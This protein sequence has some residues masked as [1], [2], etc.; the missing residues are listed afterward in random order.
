MRIWVGENGI[1]SLE[2]IKM[3]LHIWGLGLDLFLFPS[4]NRLRKELN[5]THCDPL[6]RSGCASKI[7]S[8]SSLMPRLRLAQ[9]S[10]IKALYPFIWSRDSFWIYSHLYF[11]LYFRSKIIYN[12]LN[13]G[14]LSFFFYYPFAPK[15]RSS[16]MKRSI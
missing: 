7:D 11:L 1:T 6:A 10:F 14:L 2:V 4:W 12:N 8:L 16:H 13:S 3:Y 5:L 9:S 15:F